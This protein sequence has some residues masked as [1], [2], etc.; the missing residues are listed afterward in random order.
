M[1]VSQNQVE[2]LTKEILKSFFSLS[3]FKERTK[4][5]N[6]G[7]LDGYSKWTRESKL[8]L[9]E[10][11][12]PGMDMIEPFS[13]KLDIRFSDKIGFSSLFVPE[14]LLTGFEEG[15]LKRIEEEKSKIMSAIEEKKKDFTERVKG[16]KRLTVRL[17]QEA[18]SGKQASL[19]TTLGEFSA[20]V[21]WSGNVSM[22][23]LIG[24][25]RG[26]IEVAED[27][28][29]RFSEEREGS[30]EIIWNL[31]E[32]ISQ[33]KMKPVLF[34]WNG[35]PVANVF[36]PKILPMDQVYKDSIDLELIASE[37]IRIYKKH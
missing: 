17:K 20:Y 36:M 29:E 25:A 16:V 7:A 2:T 21:D 3:P 37:L 14:S 22:S 9:A 12:F 30:L 34:E 31:S 18:E 13:L 6:S 5:Y 8:R 19:V 35:K 32:A 24:T 23:N 1:P 33:V 27:N 15:H 28:M 26:I 4:E 11:F 10:L